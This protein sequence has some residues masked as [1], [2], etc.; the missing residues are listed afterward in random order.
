MR[1]V[2]GAEGK[3]TAAYIEVREDAFTR[4][5]RTTNFY[6]IVLYE[7]DNKISG[8]LRGNVQRST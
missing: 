1:R 4:W 7:E 8:K 3:S 6:K 5:Q 2:V